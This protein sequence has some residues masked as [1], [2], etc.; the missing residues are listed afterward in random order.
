M[1]KCLTFI[2]I[3]AFLSLFSGCARYPN[4]QKQSAIQDQSISKSY[5]RVVF[6]KNNSIGNT[7]IDKTEFVATI[8][9]GVPADNK[10]TYRIFELKDNNFY[11]I[12]SFEYMRKNYPSFYIDVPVGK[13]TF[14]IART[15]N[16][17]FTTHL[18][19]KMAAV[20]LDVEEYK[21]YPLIFGI[22]KV[23]SSDRWGELLAYHYN[24]SDEDLSYVYNLRKKHLSG[25]ERE[26]IISDINKYSVA[27]NVASNAV[28]HMEK[29]TGPDDEF[30]KFSKEKVNDLRKDFAEIPSDKISRKSFNIYR[31]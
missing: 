26:K 20:E 12:E 7:G 31:K 28:L 5:G 16:L 27:F 21:T 14:V 25:K 30:I 8:M 29:S 15:R 6:F 1:K 19:G 24:L 13:H 3:I 9:T 11:P 18:V 10:I 22:G 17:F 23:F 4:L 2:P